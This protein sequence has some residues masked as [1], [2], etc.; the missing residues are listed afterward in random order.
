[1]DSE[2]IHKEL[3]DRILRAAIEVHRF[4]GPGLLESTYEACLLD[5]LQ[6]DGLAVARQLELPVFYKDRLIECGY[7]IDLLVDNKV[8]I[9]V[10]AV[11]K[12]APVH[13]AQLMTYLRLSGKQV[14]LVLNFNVKVLPDGI[15]RRVVS[16][17]ATPSALSASSVVNPDLG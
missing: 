1:M 6:R 3:T 4:L 13:T 7:R 8:I 15:V 2:L 11:E 9:E 17:P 16:Q 10:K 12:L 14:G 5:E